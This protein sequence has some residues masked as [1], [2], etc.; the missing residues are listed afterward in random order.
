MHKHLDKYPPAPES[1][2]EHALQIFPY[3]EMSPEEYA[4]RNAHDWLCFSFDEYIY[5][6]SELNEWIHTLGDIFFTKGAVRAA[7]EKYLTREQIAAVEERENE[8][9]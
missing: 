4:A 3:K 6:N 8:P 2:E 9:F 1:R 7:R 5:N